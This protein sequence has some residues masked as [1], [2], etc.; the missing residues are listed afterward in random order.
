MVRGY[1]RRVCHTGTLVKP[2]MSIL[3]HGKNA[4]K[5]EDLGINHKQ[6]GPDSEGQGLVSPTLAE[7]IKT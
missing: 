5:I 7:S 2:W 6:S 3:S 1:R 4:S